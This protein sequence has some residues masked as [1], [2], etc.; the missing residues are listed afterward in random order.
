MCFWQCVFCFLFV[1]GCQ[2]QSEVILGNYTPVLDCN[3][4]WVCACFNLAVFNCYD[5]RSDHF[6]G[7]VSG[8]FP[9][10]HLHCYTEEIVWARWHYIHVVRLAGR[11][12]KNRREFWQHLRAHFFFQHMIVLFTQSV[13]L[14]VHAVVASVFFIYYVHQNLTNMFFSEFSRLT[15]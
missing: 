2:V 8:R 14:L 15:K 12:K 7:M 11:R 9:S 4:V 13:C 6:H 5:L 10:M 1:Y 3:F